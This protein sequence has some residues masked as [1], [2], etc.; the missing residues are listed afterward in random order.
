MFLDAWLSLGIFGM[1]MM[2]LAPVF[3]LTYV[4]VVFRTLIA[5]LKL[6]RLGDIEQLWLT[7]FLLVLLVM[8]PI[9]VLAIESA[10]RILVRVRSMALQLRL[11]KVDSP[12]RIG[13]C[14]SRQPTDTPACFLPLP[15]W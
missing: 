6:R 11:V 9:S 13:S 15:I 3:L 10:R 2:F 4:V 7:V 14:L 12:L 1:F 8:L 5:C